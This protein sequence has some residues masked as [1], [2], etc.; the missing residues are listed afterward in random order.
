M[1]REILTYPI[2]RP[3]LEAE[4]A[5]LAEHFRGLGCDSCTAFFGHAWGEHYPQDPWTAVALPL[6]ALVAEVSRIEEAGFGALGNDD[7]FITIAPF[8]LE[9]RFCNDSD[10]HLSFEAPSDTTEVFFQRW[11]ALGFK[12][13]EWGSAPVGQERP[14]L[15]RA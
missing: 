3:S 9:F 13:A 11:R 1:T 5:F 14:C 8:P 4:L 15:R 12:P 7:L 6:E 10:I 2:D